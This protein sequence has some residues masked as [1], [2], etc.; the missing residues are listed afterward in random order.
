MT[1]LSGCGGGEVGGVVVSP[2][3]NGACVFEMVAFE[4]QTGGL[5]RCPWRRCLT[6]MACEMDSV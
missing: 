4:S 3:G 1:L 5:V 6:Q 2:L